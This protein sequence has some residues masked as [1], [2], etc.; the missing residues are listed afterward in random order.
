MVQELHVALVDRG[1]LDLLTGAEGAVDDGAGADVPQ[2]RAHERTALAGLHVLEVDDLEQALVEIEG[3]AVL[4]VV[5]G[6][7]GPWRFAGVGHVDQ[8]RSAFGVRVSGTHPRSVTTT[9]SST[10]TPP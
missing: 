6:D 3:H 2:G 7:A 5:G 8:A 4:E 10:R 9:V 1:P